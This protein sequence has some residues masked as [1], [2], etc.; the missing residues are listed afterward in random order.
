MSAQ[1]KA[2]QEIIGALLY[3][4][5]VIDNTMLKKITELGS[6]LATATENIARK[7]D[8]FLQYA[9]TCPMRVI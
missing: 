5:R 6:L 2:I 3:Y 1:K 4:A 8:S 7:V 9:A